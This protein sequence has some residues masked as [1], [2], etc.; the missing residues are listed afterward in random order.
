[1]KYWIKNENP[2]APKVKDKKPKENNKVKKEGNQ[3]FKQNRI[4]NNEFDET[5][6]ETFFN[7]A[8]NPFSTTV[9][10]IRKEDSIEEGLAAWNFAI[11]DHYRFEATNL[12]KRQLKL[13]AVFS[14]CCIFGE[15]LSNKLAMERYKKG[16]LTKQFGSEN[17][18]QVKAYAP[19]WNKK[20]IMQTMKAAMRGNKNNNSLYE[21]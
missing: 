1:M 13:L 12:N 11:A 20:K 9:Q 3:E 14:D 17:K 6:Q 16:W 8:Q 10:T 15:T 21:D 19:Y 4:I 5:N 7:R 18:T 2:I